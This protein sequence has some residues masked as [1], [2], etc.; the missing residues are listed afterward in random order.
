MRQ[1]QPI[2]DPDI[3]RV[4]RTATALDWAVIYPEGETGQAYWLCLSKED[5]EKFAFDEGEEGF[6]TVSST[7]VVDEQGVIHDTA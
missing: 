3:L 1:G 4:L 2:Y 7:A 6:V 5:R